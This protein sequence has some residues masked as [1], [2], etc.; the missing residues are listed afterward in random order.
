MHEHRDEDA[1]HRQ[2]EDRDHATHAWMD[3]ARRIDFSGRGDGAAV[4]LDLRS[5][6]ALRD[7]LDQV[8]A[9]AERSGVD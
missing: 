4:E 6:R 3:H 2:L 9:E 7:R 8:I 1:P 5:A